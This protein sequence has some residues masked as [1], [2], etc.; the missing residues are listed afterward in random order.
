M[1][2]DRDRFG[3]FAPRPVG[4]PQRETA[5]LVALSRD[6][7]ADVDAT[8]AAAL[9]QGGTD[10]GKPQDH[11]FMYGQSVSDPDGNVLE[12]F[13]MDPAAAAGG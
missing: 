3:G 1:L 11:G 4:E 6:S 12:F 9:A 7:R 5:V 8:L 2:L 10:N 13:W